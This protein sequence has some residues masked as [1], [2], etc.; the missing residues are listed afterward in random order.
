MWNTVTK[1]SNAGKPIKFLCNE[2]V[3][4]GVDMHKSSYSVTIWSESR[5][6]YAAHWMQPA[7]LA[8]P[9]D[10]ARASQHEAPGGQSAQNNGRRR[11]SERPAKRR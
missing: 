6:G 2:R 7:E 8:R 11:I 10:L 1:T 9:A 4:V 3:D 5:Q